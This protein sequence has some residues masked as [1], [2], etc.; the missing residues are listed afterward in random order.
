M[1]IIRKDL[2]YYFFK[3]GK[4]HKD[5]CHNEAALLL[6]NN[7]GKTKGAIGYLSS[8]E[9]RFL[10]WLIDIASGSPIFIPR[11]K[12]LKGWQRA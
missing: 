10:R 12:K 6:Q 1:G 4:W 7:I 8:I 11:R 5:I 2:P 9:Q 3:D